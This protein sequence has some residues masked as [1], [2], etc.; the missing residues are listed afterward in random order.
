M[1]LIKDFWTSKVNH[2]RIRIVTIHILFFKTNLN[3]GLFTY[4][5]SFA[6]ILLSFAHTT[7]KS[8]TIFL[9]ISHTFSPVNQ[10]C[11]TRLAKL[12][13]FMHISPIVFG[14]LSFT[15]YRTL[16]S[17]YFLISIHAKFIYQELPCQNREYKTTGIRVCAKMV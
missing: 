12:R 4:T 11:F 7:A 6:L 17:F 5:W 2:F 16:L 13:I 1:D 10:R 8:L 3:L 9:L 15:P 14:R